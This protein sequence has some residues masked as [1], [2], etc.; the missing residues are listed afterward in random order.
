MRSIVLADQEDTLVGLRLAGIEGEYVDDKDVL[1]T[2]IDDY[3][4]D[5]TIGII[6]ITKHLMDMAEEKILELKL[7][8]KDTLIIGIPNMGGEIGKDFLTNYIQ[9]S[10]GLKL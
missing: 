3:I 2:K 7:K 1:L 4:N 9:D 5:E 10:I 8:S 6:I